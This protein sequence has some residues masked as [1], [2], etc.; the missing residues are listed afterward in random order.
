MFI[1]KNGF[2]LESI[3]K[4]VDLKVQRLS[5]SSVG[6]DNEAHNPYF[7]FIAP[8]TMKG[9][10]RRIVFLGSYDQ[11]SLSSDHVVKK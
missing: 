9:D 4:N 3:D 7:M 10:E 6:L 1:S 11:K 5:Q 2:F 8:L